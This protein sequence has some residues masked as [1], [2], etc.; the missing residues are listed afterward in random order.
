MASETWCIVHAH[1]VM[2]AEVSQTVATGHLAA[3]SE[4]HG[5]RAVRVGDGPYLAATEAMG[6]SAREAVARLAVG[7]GLAV[8]EILAPGELTRAELLAQVEAYAAQLAPMTRAVDALR[9]AAVAAGHPAADG[10]PDAQFCAVRAAAWSA[11][12]EAMRRDAMRACSAIEDNRT[13]DA[14]WRRTHGPRATRDEDYHRIFGQAIGADA[15][16]DEI[17]AL[18]VPPCPWGVCCGTGEVSR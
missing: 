17:R 8:R 11:G 13:E 18:P 5:W 4:W 1:G 3:L 16:W 7:N 9:A 14:Q 6:D 10:D 12:A 2:R 15:C